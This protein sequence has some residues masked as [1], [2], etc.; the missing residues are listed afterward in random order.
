M[1]LCECV[2]LFVHCVCAEWCIFII[3]NTKKALS[4]SDLSMGEFMLHEQAN[5]CDY[6]EMFLLVYQCDTESDIE[7]MTFIK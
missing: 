5:V 6:M 1:C 2:G 7:L 3:Q 4:V